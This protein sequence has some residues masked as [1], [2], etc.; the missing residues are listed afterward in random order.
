M[1]T[2]IKVL[3]T[4]VICIVV[5]IYMTP[6]RGIEK[7]DCLCTMVNSSLQSQMHHLRVSKQVNKVP[8]WKQEL[9]L[10]NTLPHTVCYKDLLLDRKREAGVPTCC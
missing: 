1:S 9:Q 7:S 6:P 8:S 3:P 5:Q 2:Q 10:L 4:L